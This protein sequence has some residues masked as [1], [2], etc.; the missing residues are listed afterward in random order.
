MT[1]RS[2]KDIYNYYLKRESKTADNP[3]DEEKYEQMNELRNDI[4]KILE[5][6]SEMGIVDEKAP[7]VDEPD[8]IDEI[9]GGMRDRV[10][11]ILDERIKRGSGYYESLLNNKYGLRANRYIKKKKDRDPMGEYVRRHKG[12]KR[13]CVKNRWVKFLKEFRKINKNIKGPM[14]MKKASKMWKSMSDKEKNM[15]R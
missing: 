4:F 14:V 11:K 13:G 12:G 9:E 6:R 1:K 3:Y 15:F 5:N 8:T 2:D 7:Y 10:R